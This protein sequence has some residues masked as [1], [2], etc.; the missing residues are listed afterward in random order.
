MRSAL[1]VLASLVILPACS[2]VAGV[3]KDVSAVGRGIKHVADEVRDEVFSPRD[4]TRY[5]E[6]RY[7]SQSSVQPTVV[8]KEPCD[9]NAG[10]LRGGSGLPSCPRVYYKQ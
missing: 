8:V 7:T 9:P 10:E 3:G 2:T 5:V 6:Q 1:F 4:Q